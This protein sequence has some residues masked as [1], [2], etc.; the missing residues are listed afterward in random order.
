MSQI[1]VSDLTF[2]YD[3]SYELIF[4]HTSFVLD[5]D[6]KLGFIGRNGRGKTTLLQLLLGKHE[7]L[8]EIETSVQFEYFPYDFPRE[9]TALQ[10][11]KESIAPFS[12]GKDKWKLVSIPD[13]RKT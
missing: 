5:T 8:G 7:Y 10:A 3:N 13:Q 9:T 2:R 1:K 11:V 12:S 6:W 4:D